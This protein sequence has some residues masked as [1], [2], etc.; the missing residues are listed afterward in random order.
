MGLLNSILKNAAGDAVKEVSNV[1]DNVITSDEERLKA[2]SELTRIITEKLSELAQ[3]QRDVLLQELQGNKLQRNW[4]P[5]VM[6]M[7]AFIV[8]YAKFIAPAFGLPNTELEPYFWNLLEIGIG[9]YVIGRTLEKVTGKVTDNIDISFI[10][11][12]SRKS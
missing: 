5:V 9:G 2:K 8:V 4:R 3:A 6:L 11:R 7:F 10:K 1:L 12:K